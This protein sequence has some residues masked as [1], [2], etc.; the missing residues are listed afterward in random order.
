VNDAR[1]TLPSIRLDWQALLA[2]YMV[3]APT[4][5]ALWSLA[6]M[7]EQCIGE[8]VLD[9]TCYANR[10]WGCGCRPREER[11]GLYLTKIALTRRPVHMA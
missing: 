1:Q 3:S 7:G 2:Q 5:A 9:A 8:I 10:I 4:I 11:R 6:E